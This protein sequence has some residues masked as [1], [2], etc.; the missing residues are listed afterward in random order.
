MKQISAKGRAGLLLFKPWPNYLLT[1]FDGTHS[2][3]R[4]YIG[5][6]NECSIPM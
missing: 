1:E 4:L 5:L 3:E 2:T 6:I